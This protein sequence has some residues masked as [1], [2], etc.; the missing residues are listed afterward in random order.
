MKQQFILLLPTCLLC[1]QL[2]AA[3]YF[4]NQKHLVA[5]TTI[6]PVPPGQLPTG[7]L[8]LAAGHYS[9]I[10]GEKTETNNGVDDYWLVKND[11]QNNIQWQRTLG[12]F[13]VDEILALAQTKD[14]GYI[15]AGN[16]AS[17]PSGDK[18]DNKGVFDFWVIKLNSFGSVEWQ[19][20]IGWQFYRFCNSVQQTKDNSGYLIGG[21]SGRMLQA[22]SRNAPTGWL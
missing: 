6:W 14:G 11:K 20:N 5:I 13:D 7:A 8:C 12:G 3:N 16:S 18:A 19:K 2:C 4:L 17:F 22:I 15:L 10:S 1:N 21:S 9:P